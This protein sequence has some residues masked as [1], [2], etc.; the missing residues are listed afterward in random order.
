MFILFNSIPTNKDTK[1]LST[2][3][4]SI[5]FFC[6]TLTTGQLRVFFH[7]Y[8]HIYM[9]NYCPRV[10]IGVRVRCYLF[11]Y[12]FFPY[13]IKDKTPVSFFQFC[14]LPIQY[15]VHPGF[16]FF[17]SIFYC[18]L[19]CNVSILIFLFFFIFFTICFRFLFSP[20]ATVFLHVAFPSL[21]FFASFILLKIPFLHLFVLFLH[22]GFLRFCFDQIS[23]VLS[24]SIFYK[25][26]K[27]DMDL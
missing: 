13:E 16:L 27:N 11:S 20:F 7:P 8:G 4:W 3:C 1:F 24:S 22:V 23:T 21:F 9:G 17:F 5:F 18:F 19:F 26:K 6:F 10:K 14:F 2:F 12:S 25:F 15:H